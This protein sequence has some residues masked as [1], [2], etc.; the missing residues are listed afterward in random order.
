MIIDYRGYGNSEGTP[1]E[2]G[3][4]LDAQATLD[5]I[6]KREDIDQTKL[7]VFGRSLGGAVAVQL[8]MDPIVP[9]KGIILENTFT[10]IPDMM[11]EL[12]PVVSLF[13]RYGLRF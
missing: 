5:F 9:I 11:D 12:F 3:L 7:Y 10:S 2:G 8:C 1:S 6:S 4:K 13:K